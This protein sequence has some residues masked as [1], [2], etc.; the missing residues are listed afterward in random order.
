[1]NNDEIISWLLDS[2]Y[3]IQYQVYKDLLGE[4][5]P[6]LRMKIAQ[7][8]WGKELLSR[9]KPD[10]HWGLSYYQ[11]KWICTHYTRLDFC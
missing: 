8:G 7:E 9:Q 3:S 1:M 2:D 6:A 4:E 11:P 5:K 10:G